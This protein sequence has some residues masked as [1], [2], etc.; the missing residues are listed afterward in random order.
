M[1]RRTS[2]TFSATV[3]STTARH[4]RLVRSLHR[5]L[6]KQSWA[7]CHYVGTNCMPAFPPGIIVALPPGLRDIHPD[8]VL[9]GLGC[10]EGVV[11]SPPPHL[12]G[13]TPGD[14]APTRRVLLPWG[15][16][17]ET[18][19]AKTPLTPVLVSLDGMPAHLLNLDLGQNFA[20]IEQTIASH[21]NVAE[22]SISFLVTTYGEEPVPTKLYADTLPLARLEPHLVFR[23]ASSTAHRRDRSQEDLSPPATP[24][25]TGSPPED[26][27]QTPATPPDAARSEDDS[28]SC[29]SPANRPRVGR[30][31]SFVL[32]GDGD[33]VVRA[34][35]R[36]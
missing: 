36:G 20:I 23:V 1:G 17:M 6:G 13:Q 15:I 2:L 21:F 32:N 35:H 5:F 30:R 9:G 31:M 28:S 27:L 34:Y 10:P 11:A 3:H 26:P 14:H 8:L 18:A 29:S 12:P 22:I 25:V 7:A 19:G 24:T 4:D 16:K 33:L